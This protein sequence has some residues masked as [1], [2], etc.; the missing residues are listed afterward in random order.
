MGTSPKLTH[1]NQPPSL[2]DERLRFGRFSGASLGLALGLG[3]WLPPILRLASVPLPLFALELALGFGALILIGLCAGHISAWVDRS[4]AS[5]VIWAGAGLLMDWVV[6]H[7][8]FEGQT[9]LI[10]LL[11]SRFWG[12][13]IYPS[14]AAT[15]LRMGVAGFFFVLLLAIYGLLQ[16]LRL[17]G[18]QTQLDERRRLTGGGWFQLLIVLIPA[19]AVGVIVDDILFKPVFAAPR[20]VHEAIQ[21]ARANDADDLF[22]LSLDSAINYNV[23]KGVHDQLDGPYTLQIG[24][25][26]LGLSSEFSIVADFENGAWLNCTLLADNLNNCY[27]MSAPYVRGFPA[28]IATG[29]LPAD[30]RACNI[31]VTPAQA[32][33]LDQRRAHLG[34]VPVV[35]VLAQRGSHVLMRAT[36][37]SGDYAFD[38]FLVGISPVSLGTCRDVQ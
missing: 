15:Q 10:W 33:D 17:D 38:C 28:L 2:R 6:G 23:L 24:E 26:R 11:D 30:C 14:T 27:D 35:D 8:L 21:V 31:R 32:A 37:A 20:V 3:L 4:L 34:L 36:S 16:S 12:Q 13:V 7:L 19:L 18:L 5:M 22:D 29:N 9:W 25:I 1:N